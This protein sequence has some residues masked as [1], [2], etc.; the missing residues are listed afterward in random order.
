A[1]F[2]LLALCGS[3]Q[4]FDCPSGQEKSGLLCYTK[5][6]EGYSCQASLCVA[7]C[8]DGY[9][10]TGIGT[11]HYSA[12]TTYTQ[13]PYISRS[14]SGMQRCLALFYNDCRDRYH[15]DVCGI[16][17]YKGKWDTLRASYDRGP[18]VSPDVSAA[19]RQVGI[20]A[21]TTYGRALF[22]A[23]GFY[24]QALQA[25]T[26]GMTDAIKSQATSSATDFVNQHKDALTLIKTGFDSMQNDPEMINVMRRLV[27]AASKGK[28]DAQI[29]ADI[30]KIADKVGATKLGTGWIFGVQGGISAAYAVGGYETIGI[31]V[32]LNTLS[33]TPNVA[34][35]VNEGLSLG[36]SF[37]AD[38]QLGIFVQQGKVS[39][40][41]WQGPTMGISLSQ[42]VIPQTNVSAEGVSYQMATRWPVQDGTLVNPDV[43][44]KALRDYFANGQWGFSLSASVGVAKYPV[45]AT[46]D[47]GTEFMF[48]LK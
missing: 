21:Q 30:K 4:A 27:V 38:L 2:G 14:H 24:N 23:Q 43:F 1:L 8:P 28:V 31:A 32:D 36:P 6:R 45:S 20:V 34:V 39:R 11:C 22:G 33:T 48:Q 18:G 13:K 44:A 16:C 47:F 41:T 25:F 9:H 5:P 7:N 19:F 3:A 10:S 40:Q 15:M 26:D 12:S 42:P 46:V 37:G 35:M 29:A 17:S